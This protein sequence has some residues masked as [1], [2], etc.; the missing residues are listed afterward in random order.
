MVEADAA[1]ETPHEAADVNLG[2]GERFEQA[3]DA[4]EGVGA[5]RAD[6]GAFPEQAPAAH[7]AAE[8]GRN[9]ARMAAPA[10]ARAEAR[11]SLEEDDAL[12][13]ALDVIEEAA[14]QPAPPRSAECGQHAQE[15]HQPSDRRSGERF[16][17]GF[18][19]GWECVG[20]EAHYTAPANRSD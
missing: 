1:G 8:T 14:H 3:G 9:G 4:G 11:D 12:N 20:H 6:A 16:E 17:Y 19:E 15:P 18:G 2:I 5:A 7:G 10:R 13:G